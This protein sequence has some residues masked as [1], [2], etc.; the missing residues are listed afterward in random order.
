MLETAE[1]RSKLWVSLSRSILRNDLSPDA[2]L[3]ADWLGA[4][5]VAS[6]IDLSNIEQKAI[7]RAH[8]S[9]DT[10]CL[11]SAAVAIM[12]MSPHTFERYPKLPNWSQSHPQP[13]R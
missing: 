9:F 7:G 11:L 10:E 4:Q 8:R 3:F 1:Y 6:K 2:A 13:R 12:A 5:L